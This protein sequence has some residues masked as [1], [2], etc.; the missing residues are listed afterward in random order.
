MLRCQERAGSDVARAIRYIDGEKNMLKMMEFID[1]YADYGEFY[2]VNCS[3]NDL[4]KYF[5]E[6]YNGKEKHVV[7]HGDYL[8][9]KNKKFQVLNERNFFKKYIVLP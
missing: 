7:K 6:F 1:R 4:S 9:F 8:V 5:I 2:R 3:E